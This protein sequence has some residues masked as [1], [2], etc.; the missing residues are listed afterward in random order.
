MFG[1]H[2]LHGRG[3]AVPRAFAISQ[4]TRTC[5]EM[6]ICLLGISLHIARGIQL[7]GTIDELAYMP[8]DALREFMPELLASPFNLYNLLRVYET[9]RYG[10]NLIF[11]QEC[12]RWSIYVWRMIEKH[13]E[14]RPKLASILI[15]IGCLKHFHSH[16]GSG[17]ITLLPD[18]TSKDRYDLVQRLSPLP[19]KL[20]T[21]NDLAKVLKNISNVHV[22]RI[23]YEW[24]IEVG[25][26]GMS[27]I[28]CSNKQFLESGITY[29][30]LFPLDIGNLSYPGVKED[31]FALLEGIQK[32]ADMFGHA[33]YLQ[34]LI[35]D[36]NYFE[37]NGRKFDPETR[38]FLQMVL[39]R[40]QRRLPKCH[41]S[42]KYDSLEEFC[43]YVNSWPK[44]KVFK[45][46]SKINRLLQN[47]D[48]LSFGRLVATIA[49]KIQVGCTIFLSRANRI[50]LQSISPVQQSACY[51]CLN[52]EERINYFH[53]W[54]RSLPKWI[55]QKNRELVDFARNFGYNFYGLPPVLGDVPLQDYLNELQH[56]LAEKVKL[57]LDIIIE[58]D[59]VIDLREG[60]EVSPTFGMH[61]MM[62]NYILVS[63]AKQ[64]YCG[65][66]ERFGRRLLDWINIRANG[67]EK[68]KT[69]RDL[70]DHV[71]LSQHLP[72]IKGVRLRRRLSRAI[73]D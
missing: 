43:Y 27:R 19:L 14:N 71:M 3:G 17:D 51:R 13:V 62:F 10:I 52:R 30:V 56:S 12:H 42:C 38:D 18:P 29:R 40:L 41:K 2:Y 44:K 23:H 8:R 33:A 9:R 16:Y 26:T 32:S 73:R 63:L 45:N 59:L 49:H 60:M 57:Q 39:E 61:V 1:N 35:N 31:Y 50:K 64:L 21:E 69:W 34:L 37:G 4:E 68:Q 72:K 15:P 6:R 47:T 7:F 20:E 54:T 66:H 11:E 55:P 28:L 22:A 48:L 65:S 36:F 53:R 25:T 70:M 5:K 46:R 24:L 58:S 67:E